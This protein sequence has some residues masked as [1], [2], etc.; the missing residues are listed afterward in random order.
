ME[1]DPFGFDFELR[2]VGEVGDA[3]VV[4][5]SFVSG[6]DDGYGREFVDAARGEGFV[7]GDL[8]DADSDAGF[9]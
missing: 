3:D 6:V 9:G 1:G 4:G 5:G 8:A 7:D 2:L